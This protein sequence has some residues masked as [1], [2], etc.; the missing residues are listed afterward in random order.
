VAGGQDCI[1]ASCVSI[2]KGEQYAT[3]LKDTRKLGEATVKLVDD[4]LSGRKPSGLDT[5]QY[6]NGSIVVPSL[7]LQSTIV[8]KS[9]LKSAVVDTGYHTAAECGF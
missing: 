6:N 5:K 2:N 9:N 7:L 4:V 1:V 8:T 3:I